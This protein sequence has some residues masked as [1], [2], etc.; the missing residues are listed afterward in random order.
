MS[1]P[2]SVNASCLPLVE[3][4]VEGAAALAYAG[5]LKVADAMLDQGVV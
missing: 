1:Q 3:E 4:L 2:L 5:F